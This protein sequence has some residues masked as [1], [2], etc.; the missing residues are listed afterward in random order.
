MSTA[1]LIAVCVGAWVGIFGL[2]VVACHVADLVA[3]TVRR[4]AG[5]P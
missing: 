1:S 5:R 2:M 4:K 3:R